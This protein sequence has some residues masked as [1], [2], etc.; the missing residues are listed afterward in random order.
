MTALDDLLT[1]PPFSL[2][3]KEK[4]HALLPLLK[5]LTEHHRNTCAPYRRMIDLAFP[6]V[7]EA[8][9]LAQLPYLPI[10]LFKFRRLRSIAESDIRVTVTSS[11]TTGTEKSRIELDAA[12]AKLS[13]RALNLIINSVTGARRLPMLIVDCEASIKGGD[14]MGARA[15]AILGL[16]PFGRDH[17]FALRDNLGVDEDKIAAFLKRHEGQDILIY[18][19]TF[20]V[21]QHFITACEKNS[22][23]FSRGTLLHSGGWKKLA[24]SAVDNNAF[25]ARLKKAAGIGCVMNFYGM[26]ELPGTIFLENENGLLYPPHFADVI[27]RDPITFQPLPHGQ[28]GLVQILTSL[29]RSY[30]GHS[31]LTEDMGVIEATDSDGRYGHGLRIIGRAPRA[32]LRGC[33]DVIAREAA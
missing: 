18:G 14:G 33:S 23:D 22:Y 29:P 10:S 15:A 28:P 9:T 21:W 20:L 27:I 1:A 12:T 32:E 7:A 6:Q 31:L 24:E 2:P 11:G 3:Q 25:K 17:C 30:P 5:E 13:S 16:M 19:F 26:A 8:S 4:E